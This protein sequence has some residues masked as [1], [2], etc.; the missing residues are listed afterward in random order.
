M[1]TI[2][3]HASIN[4]VGHVQA[5]IQAATQCMVVRTG[6]ACTSGRQAFAVLGASNREWRCLKRRKAIKALNAQFN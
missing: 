1:H 5:Q 4:N 2:T 3:V 6:Y